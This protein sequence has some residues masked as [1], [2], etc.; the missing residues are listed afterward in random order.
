MQYSFLLISNDT[1]FLN[2]I[3]KLFEHFQNYFCSGLLVS[4]SEAEILETI[5]IKKP[6][7]V[8]F[9]NLKDKDKGLSFSSI[10][11]MHQFLDVMPYFIVISDEREDAIEA[12]QNGIS[13]FWITPL[14]ISTLGKS[15]FRFEKLYTPRVPQNICIKSYSDY[16]FINLMDIIYLK[17]DNNTTDIFLRNNNIIT[18]YKTLKHFEITLPF[19]FSRIHK[20]HIVNVHHVSRIHFSKSKCYLNFNQVLPFTSNYRENIDLILNNIR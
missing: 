15:L 20:S 19:Y 7:L 3:A 13:D 16:H 18:A 17:A 6:N 8:I 11:E 12:I 10:N 14:Q 4:G 1:I 2:S 9:Q 5:C